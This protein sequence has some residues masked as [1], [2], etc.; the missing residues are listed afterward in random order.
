M[1]IIKRGKKPTNIKRFECNNCGTVLEAGPQ[2]YETLHD[3][4]EQTLI[5]SIKCPICDNYITIHE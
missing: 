3:Y 2:E 1:K 5:Y 4:R